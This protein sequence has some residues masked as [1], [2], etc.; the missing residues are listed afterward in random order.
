MSEFIIKRPK[1][2]ARRLNMSVSTIYG[3]N[4]KIKRQLKEE[5]KLP[6]KI[7]ELKV[8]EKTELLENFK[9]FLSSNCHSF[10]T[11][12]NVR[13][14]IGKQIQFSGNPSLSTIRAWMKGELGMSF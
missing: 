10:Y 4:R 13:D 2:L 11:T 14:H 8:K 1:L 3:I 6:F 12:T 5:N 9:D 7:K